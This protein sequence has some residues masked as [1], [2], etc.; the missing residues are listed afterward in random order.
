[1]KNWAFCWGNLK[2]IGTFFGRFR[3]KILARQGK[4]VELLENIEFSKSKLPAFF[5]HVE[6]SQLRRQC[7]KV[8]F[9]QVWAVCRLN[10]FKATFKVSQ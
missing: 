2:F 10:L 5:H 9:V 1:M 8:N 7:H 6:T 4:K 3:I